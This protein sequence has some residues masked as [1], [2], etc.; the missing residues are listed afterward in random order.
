MNFQF[1]RNMKN[2]GRKQPALHNMD[3]NLYINTNLYFLNIS[4]ISIL[5]LKQNAIL[6][7]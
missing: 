6:F 5:I 2:G 7:D 4:N 1:V 3:I